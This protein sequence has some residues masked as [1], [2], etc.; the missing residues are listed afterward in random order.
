M[1]QN[2]RFAVRIRRKAQYFTLQID[3]FDCARILMRELNTV[4]ERRL[5]FIDWLAQISLHDSCFL[6]IAVFFFAF[7]ILLVFLKCVF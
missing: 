6:I 7:S 2:R 1:K 5:S 3:T 4:F